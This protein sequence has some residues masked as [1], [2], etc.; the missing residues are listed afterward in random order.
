MFLF[1]GLHKTTPTESIA[2]PEKRFLIPAVGSHHSMI[3]FRLSL[4]F[5]VSA[6]LVLP[7]RKGVFGDEIGA[8]GGG[9]GG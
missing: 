3:Q 9:G 5:F 2:T 7:T 6:F 8:R 4:F 1:H